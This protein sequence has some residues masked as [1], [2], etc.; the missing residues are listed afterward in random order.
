MLDSLQAS[1]A[2]LRA[3][4]QAAKPNYVRV[5][6]SDAVRDQQ[7]YVS[8]DRACDTRRLF[9]GWHLDRRYVS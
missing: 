2:E 3:M 6:K 1:P 7:Q 5:L 9:P 8:A 4:S